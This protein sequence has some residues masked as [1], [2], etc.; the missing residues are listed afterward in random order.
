MF[1]T[2]LSKSV[3]VY[4]PVASVP[5]ERLLTPIRKSEPVS[6]VWREPPELSSI[7][8]SASEALF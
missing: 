1:L 5:N 8:V 3:A 4:W 6:I 2:T 7:L